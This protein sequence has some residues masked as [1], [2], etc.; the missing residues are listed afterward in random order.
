[1]EESSFSLRATHDLR[2]IVAEPLANLLFAQ[3]A[4]V[5]RRVRPVRLERL[6]PLRMLRVQADLANARG[7]LR[8]VVDDDFFSL[9]FA[10]I[11][12]FVEHFLCR[13]E[14]QRRLVVR[15]L[16]SVRCLND[17]A[18]FPV[19]RIEK[20]HVA[21]RA[22][23]NAQLFAEPDDLAVEIAQLLLRLPPC[24]RAA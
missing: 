1:M 24:P 11:T 20:M 16:E 18:E 21:R 3:V 22:D 2:R 19:L 8:R 12:E 7:D 23:R 10:Q 15:V 14:I 9:R 4:D 13:F 17:R 5:V 6:L